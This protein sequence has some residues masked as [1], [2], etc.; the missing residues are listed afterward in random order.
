MKDYNIYV[1]KAH[2][3]IV[4]E[5]LSDV[6]KNGLEGESSLLISFQTNRD[7]VIIPDFVRAKYPTEIS[8]ILQYQFENLIVNDTSFSVDLAFGGVLTTIT[9]PFNALTQFADQSANFGFML[10]PIEATLKEEKTSNEGA[11]VIDLER[12]RKK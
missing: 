10:M 1:Q 12:F 7:D 5:I 6:A 3:F 8:I 2:R 9:V 11:E 4:K